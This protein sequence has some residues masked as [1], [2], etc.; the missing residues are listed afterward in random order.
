MK[1]TVLLTI[2]D[3]FGI[4]NEEHGNAVK[5][6]AMPYYHKL[7]E[8]YSAS[9]LRAD[10]EFVGLP[11]GQMGNSE[12]GHLNIG[13]GRIV[14]QSL[15]RINKVTKDE[16][17]GEIPEIQVAFE[18]ALDKSLHLF[19]LLS[20]GGVH[21]HIEHLFGLLKAAQK[22]GV[23]NIYVHAILDGRDVAPASSMEFVDRLEEEFK[24]L[25]VGKLAS[26][27]GR[28][29]AMDRDKRWDRVELAYNTIVCGNSENEFRDAKEYIQSSYDN[30]VYDEFIRP[31]INA[32]V[33][34]PIESNDSVIC[35]NF[36]PDRAVQLSAV[37]TNENYNPKPDEPIF[38]PS[39]RPQNL[40]FVQMMKYSDEVLGKIA[41]KHI[42][43]ANT[44]GEVVAQKGLQQLRIAETEKYPHVTYFFD[45]GVEKDLQNAKR[46]LI[47]SPKVATYDLKPEMSA[48]QVTDSLLE[49]LEKD[50]LDVVI[51]NYANPDMV[52]HSGMLKPTIKALE[53]VDACLER[54]IGKIEEIGGVAL[55]TADH[56][57]SELVTNDDES[58]NTAHTT[59]PVPIVLVSKEYGIKKGQFKLADI[60][61]SMLQL[62]GIEKPKE[63]TGE[64]FI[65]EK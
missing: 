35:F 59:N 61:P 50:Y 32:D 13:A 27:S 46:I 20:D 6:A 23:K 64:S 58:P 8:Q 51:L 63:M 16:S 54:I 34:R 2:L 5:Q 22:A 44:F 18:N 53:T 9:E 62:L 15:E 3:G 30:E 65:D 49:E 40:K 41:F 19:G 4:R 60:A 57:N 28:Y 37:M 45:G 48:E 1:Q 10:G 52:G 17:F 26:I 31:A 56:G 25:G 14:Y 21:S 38:K 36:R 33:K 24:R 39:Y 7:L 42:D 29:F 55:I 47:N 43:L 11:S 12:V